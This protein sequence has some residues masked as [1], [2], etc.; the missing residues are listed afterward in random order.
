MQNFQHKT[1][2]GM[3]IGNGSWRPCS[4]LLKT[5]TTPLSSTLKCKP[6][7]LS[8]SLSAYGVLFGGFLVFVVDFL[9]GVFLPVQLLPNSSSILSLWCL[10]SFTAAQEV[11]MC[12]C[13]TER[14]TQEKKTTLW[15]L[16]G[17]GREK[18]D[19]S[20]LSVSLAV[21]D[22]LGR[23]GSLLFQLEKQPGRPGFSFQQ[24]SGWEEWGISRLWWWAW[25]FSQGNAKGL[26]RSPGEKEEQHW[27]VMDSRAACVPETAGMSPG[28]ETGA[29]V[30]VLALL[31]HHRIIMVLIRDHTDFLNLHI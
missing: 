13:K 11:C 21:L 19:I 12:D 14:R 25:R 3:G 22:L 24:L 26:W 16:T 20:L 6:S 30:P 17:R 18:T 27:W 10:H 15:K 7:M 23:T 8:K 29:S 9:F 5:F 2:C 1:T 31:F 28:A 4:W